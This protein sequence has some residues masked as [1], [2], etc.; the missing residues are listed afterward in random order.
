[1]RSPFP[2]GGP[3][4]KVVPTACSRHRQ[5]QPFSG[6]LA[7]GVGQRIHPPRDEPGLALFGNGA[8]THGQLALVQPEIE[9]DDDMAATLAA[10]AV[11]ITRATGF[12]RGTGTASIPIITFGVVTLLTK[13]GEASTFK[14]TIE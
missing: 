14:M 2:G 13:D 11:R 9:A 1:M 8:E 6:L 3:V 12:Y 10:L 4:P 7:L 5:L